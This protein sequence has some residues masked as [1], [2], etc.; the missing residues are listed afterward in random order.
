MKISFLSFLLTSAVVACQGGGQDPDKGAQTPQQP[1]PTGDELVAEMMKTFQEN[2]IALDAKKGTVTIPAVVNSPRDPIEYLLIHEKG[3]KHEAVFVTEAQPSILN[4]ALLAIGFEPGKNASYVEKDPPPTLEEVRS[5]VDPLIITA[6]KGK[7]FF[8]T[9]RWK[10][11]D[12]KQVEHCVEELLLDLT[13]QEPM[14]LCEWVYMGG[15]MA[16]LY[17][18]EPEVYMADLEGNLI[19]VCYLLPDNH[20]GTMS[21]ERARDDQNWW[22]TNLLPEGG[23]EIEFVFHNTEPARRVEWRK[24]QAKK[25][26]EAKDAKPPEPGSNGKP[27]AR[28][29]G[30]GQTGGGGL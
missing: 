8:M 30:G 11:A 2:G 9:A 27:S 13:T 14:G 29:S 1:Q 20:L 10:D 7:P 28:E 6:P 22:T 16:V 12:G 4:A 23:T 21:H 15:R 18:G 24:K 3:K 5:G 17:K 19:S 25:A 26:A